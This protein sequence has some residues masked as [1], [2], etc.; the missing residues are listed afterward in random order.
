[1]PMKKAATV[2]EYL[3][4]VPPKPR[5]ILEKV[6]KAIHAAAPGSVEVISYG[7]LGFKHR[8]RMLVY[9]A[10]FKNH[11]S[12]YPASKALLAA[13]RNELEGFEASGKGT[14]RFT[15]DNPL[16]VGLVKKLVKWRIQESEAKAAKT[17]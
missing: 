15:V 8:G 14:L 10:A 12:F 1:M 9:L 13:F 2:G 3:R 7:I 11:C 17:G 16:P 6:R 5:A 4:A